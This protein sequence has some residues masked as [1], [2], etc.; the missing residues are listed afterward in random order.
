MFITDT[1]QLYT[2]IHICIDFNNTKM[3]KQVNDSFTF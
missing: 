1:W 3:Q 2:V